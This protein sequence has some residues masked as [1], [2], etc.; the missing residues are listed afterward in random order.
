MQHK[1]LIIEDDPTI[2][3]LLELFLTS[4]GFST[5]FARDG[6]EGLLQFEK[7]HPNLVL[8]DLMMPKLGG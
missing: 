2:C 4:N 5:V 3:E 7:E 1:I 6:Y 8:L